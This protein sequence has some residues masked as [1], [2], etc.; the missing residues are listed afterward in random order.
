MSLI[1]AEADTDNWYIRACVSGIF[2]RLY[3]VDST[4]TRERGDRPKPPYPPL[5]EVTRVPDRID[6]K[7]LK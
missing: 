4:E 1:E 7:Q 2:R 3:S 6:V 5:A